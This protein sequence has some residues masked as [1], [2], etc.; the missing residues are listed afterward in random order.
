[1]SCL[2]KLIERLLKPILYFFLED[3]DILFKQQSG[4][5]KNKGA[6]DNLTFFTQKLSENINRGKKAVGIFFDIYIAFDKA[7]IEGYILRT[8]F[9]CEPSATTSRI[10]NKKRTVNVLHAR[11]CKVGRFHNELFSTLPYSKFQ[12]IFGR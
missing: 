3:N 9:Y 12:R 1:M 2:S 11:P 4:F 6:S 10:F 5:R 8:Y 7:F